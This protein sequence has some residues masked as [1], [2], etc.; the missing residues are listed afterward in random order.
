[1]KSSNSNR[2]SPS[3]RG[4][5]SRKSSLRINSKKRY[6]FKLTI[7][8]TEL[9][10]NKVQKGKYSIESFGLSDVKKVITTETHA[11][12]KLN[13]I[14]KELNTVLDELSKKDKIHWDIVKTLRNDPK[15]YEVFENP[16]R[17]TFLN[18][19]LRFTKGMDEKGEIA[20][21]QV[22]EL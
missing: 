2:R 7:R 4:T 5:P 15:I 6:L 11:V 16:L 10:G 22:K 9:K 19:E 8:G 14:I 1:M 12:E 3:R 18:T 21:L 13:D 17:Y 20:I